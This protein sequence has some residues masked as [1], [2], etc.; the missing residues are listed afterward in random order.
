MSFLLKE[1]FGNE[2]AT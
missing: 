2:N 1:Y